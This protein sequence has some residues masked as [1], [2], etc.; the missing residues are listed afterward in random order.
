[1]TTTFSACLA[2]RLACLAVAALAVAGCSN[3]RET[4]GLDR[5]APDEFTVVSR[6]PLSLP[7]NYD[8][9]P[10]VPGAS[11]PQEP[12]A[13]D[14]AAGA[15]FNG[16]AGGD[17]AIASA[18]PVLPDAGVTPAPVRAAAKTAAPTAAESVFLSHAGAVNPDPAIRAKVDQETTL[19]IAADRKFVDRLIFWRT[20]EDPSSVVDAGAEAQRL[21][22]N[23]ALGKP[24][25]DGETP[26]IT[27]ER[28]AP[29]EGLF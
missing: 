12:H 14:Q 17:S 18:S 13:R 16:A 25:V 23:A 21:R 3:P 7:P 26:T 1:M 24:V 20:P 15:L 4:L 10:P 5:A 22:A 9:H 27:R 8:L 29:L 2:G 6:A 11:R 28:K 19:M